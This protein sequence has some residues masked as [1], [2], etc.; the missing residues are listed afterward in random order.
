MGKRVMN[1]C[2][3]PFTIDVEMR[4]YH[5]RAFP[6]GVIK[7]NISDYDIWLCNKLINCRYMTRVWLKDISIRFVFWRR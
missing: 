2:I 7:A 5:N 4:G 1:S 6:L 3:L